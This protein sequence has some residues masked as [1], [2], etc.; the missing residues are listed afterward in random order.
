MMR[1]LALGAAVLLAASGCGREYDTAGLDRDGIEAVADRAFTEEAWRDADDLYTELLFSYPGATRTD[2]Y[3]YRLGVANAGLRRWADADFHLRRLLSEYPGSSLSDDAQM[4]LALVGWRQRRDFRRDLTPVNEALEEVRTLLSEYP[5]SELVPE[6]MLLE[7][8][9]M[10]HL[11][12]RSLFIGQFYLRRELY[13][14][15]LLYMREALEE[16]GG[17]GC[18]GELLVSMGDLYSAMGNTFAARSAYNRA[19]DE[20]GVADDLRERAE[21]GLEQLGGR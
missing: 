14:S 3:L 7:D 19:I 12:R 4:A 5:G 17:S 10:S 21:R 16:Y 6:A 11:A 1:I 13:D 2:L 18:L 9:C 20:C 15:A 8:S